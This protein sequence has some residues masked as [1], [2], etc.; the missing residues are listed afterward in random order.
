MYHRMSRPS[1]SPSIAHFLFCHCK[2]EWISHT[3]LPFV[4]D[5][6]MRHCTQFSIHRL[7]YLHSA[8]KI[9]CNGD[10][11]HANSVGY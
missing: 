1:P 2:I 4:D 3:V 5:P 6:V 7:S 10:G 11:T 9:L 8:L